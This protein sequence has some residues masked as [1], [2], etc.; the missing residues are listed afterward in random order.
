MPLKPTHSRAWVPAELS[1]KWEGPGP[2]ENL[3]PPLGFSRR[4]LGAHFIFSFCLVGPVLG[5]SRLVS[6]PTSS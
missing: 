3:G 5:T 6:F 4:G 1:A 2:E